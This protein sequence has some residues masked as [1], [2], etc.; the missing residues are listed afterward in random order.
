MLARTSLRSLGFKEAPS[1]APSFEAG[2]EDD[3]APSNAPSPLAGKES[4]VNTDGR[5][6]LG[7]PS[8]WIG[9]LG[10]G[11]LSICTG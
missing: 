11:L 4:L 3:E 8:S 2:M 5:A 7:A 10:L 1:G 9:A 6:L